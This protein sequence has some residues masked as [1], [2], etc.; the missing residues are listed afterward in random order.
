M[1]IVIFPEAAAPSNA[2]KSYILILSDVS[3]YVLRRHRHTK[4]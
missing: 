3:F 2:G 4:T 1:A